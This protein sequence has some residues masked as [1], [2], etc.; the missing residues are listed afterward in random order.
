[1]VPIQLK[2]LCLSK[3][4][5]LADA[6]ADFSRI[7]YFDGSELS[8]PQE[9]ARDI[10][11]A[12]LNALNQY[13][14]R[15]TDSAYISES[16]VSSPFQNANFL[17]PPGLHLHWQL[18]ETLCVGEQEG[19]G[20]PQFPTVPNRWL[21][22][23]QRN[24]KTKQSWIVESD[25]LWPEGQQP[26]TK[27]VCIAKEPTGNQRQPFRY[28]GRQLSLEDW[29]QGDKTA[30]FWGQSLTAIGYGEP[31]FAAFY[32]NAH[33][34]FGF[35]DPAVET[36]DRDISYTVLGWY[37][38]SDNDYFK[39]LTQKFGSEPQ[40]TLQEKLQWHWAARGSEPTAMLCYGRIQF[41]PAVPPST[42]AQT[43]SNQVDVVLANTGTEALSSYLAQQVAKTPEVKMSKAEL[44]AYLETLQLS[45]TLEGQRLDLE[46]RLTEARH[47]KGF[48]ASAV[49]ILWVIQKV[50]PQSSTND[51]TTASESTPLAEP[52][53]P[54]FLMQALLRLNAKQAEYNQNHHK[55]EAQQDQL[56][57]DWYKYMICAYPPL[58]QLSDY[59][60][61]DRVKRFMQNQGIEPLQQ[62]QNATG[63]VYLS[64][65]EQNQLIQAS[66]AGVQNPESLAP[67]IAA[68]INQLTTQLN[69]FNQG[70][71]QS[72]E[73]DTAPVSYEL[74]AIPSPRYWQATEPVVMVVG[75]S[76]RFTN[77]P[78]RVN[79][80]NF[81]PCGLWDVSS[82]EDRTE[83]HKRSQLGKFLRG[84]L[85]PATKGV[86]NV[87]DNILKKIGMLTSDTESSY[88]G[89][90]IQTE[91]PW[92]PF[93]LEWEV[94][95]Y[96]TPKDSN[97]SSLNYSP[98]SITSSYRFDPNAEPA[99]IDLD[100]YA[101]QIP[102]PEEASFAQD[103][104]QDIYSGRSFL[105]AHAMEQQEAR[106]LDYLTQ[107]PVLARYLAEQEINLKK[108]P[109]QSQELLA[110]LENQINWQD[111]T[112][113]DYLT[114]EQRQLYIAL[115][116]TYQE[117]QQTVALSQCLSGFNAA[118]LG[119]KQTLQ[120]A[121]ADPIGFSRYQEFAQQVSEAVG[122]NII[123]APQPL[124]FFNPIRAGSCKVLRLRIVDSFGQIRTLNW[125]QT[126][127]P[128]HLKPA[129]GISDPAGAIALPPRIVQGSR[130]Q[131]RWLSNNPAHETIGTSKLASAQSNVNPIC[132][133]LLPDYLDNTIEV[134]DAAGNSLGELEIQLAGAKRWR[135]S[136]GSEQSVAAIADIP[137]PYLRRVVETLNDQGENPEDCNVFLTALVAT[138]EQ[139]WANVEPEH[140]TGDPS[141]AL[142]MGQPIAV[143]RAMVNLELQGLPAINQDWAVFEQDLARTVRTTNRFEQVIFPIRLGDPQKL[144]DGLLGY[145]LETPA[146]ELT[147]QVCIPHTGVAASPHPDILT[148]PQFLYQSVTADPHVITALI[149][150]RA[151]IHAVSGILPTKAIT[152]PPAH[153][154]TALNAISISF[155]TAPILTPRKVDLPLPQLQGYA[156]SWLEQEQD[157]NDKT[158]SEIST[159]GQI[160]QS[161]F[162]A[163][164]EQRISNNR[165]TA[166][167]EHLL[168]VGWLRS[169]H[170]KM[171]V[172]PYEE[173][174]DEHQQLAEPYQ[175]W[176]KQIEIVLDSCAIKI[177][178]P[179]FDANF[180][181]QVLRE[182]WLKLKPTVM[183]QANGGT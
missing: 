29:L 157:K 164:L 183:S 72:T 89:L 169:E 163:A 12:K 162:I 119:R 64:K 103:V 61:P 52:A 109:E 7:P 70:Q 150:P 170:G 88:P 94:A 65:N 4:Q 160:E 136:P 137:N 57:A 167:W 67:K 21:V 156:W 140:A 149:D 114:P 127:T 19:E 107:Q 179:R 78:V 53:L 147:Q 134:Y 124:N 154:V 8:A 93:F 14:D 47:E 171:I 104:V 35:H 90:I 10:D 158:W 39:T 1:M 55:I 46:A 24:G 56:F 148:T 71:Q 13:S 38:H 108:N 80:E 66:A 126:I 32:P 41:E 166:V 159:I 178:S 45:G 106:L 43:P 9:I 121:I 168:A 28:L 6:M 128:E 36:M 15:N 62:L 91:P 152:V 3:H 95:F 25:Y 50:T 92:N 30:E 77:A 87:I 144:S 161:A 146:G 74:K 175:Q 131:L 135:G 176:Q 165:G 133:W 16:I 51:Q 111:K 31:A 117:L 20:E 81:L 22:V 155:L 141:I 23:R 99:A 27:T 115:L 97:S 76:A 145:W 139:A 33:S 132:G 101:E 172:T 5:L 86:D 100:P 54:N 26:P 85:Q 42:S 83:Q 142:L 17:A 118:L 143:V 48:M 96:P 59:P 69:T 153:Y 84:Q 63:T 44:E 98:T 75:E 122:S 129:T 34:V 112:H 11:L 79:E 113:K 138:L 151:A 60:H 58:G 130:L 49:D 173:R 82:T 40:A 116:H 174:P 102:L 110:W 2:G 125:E 18:P 73:P 180:S 182:G 105:S 181:S 120:L 177:R 68:E 123:S 37:S